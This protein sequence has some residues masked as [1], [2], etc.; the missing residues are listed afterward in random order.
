M[1]YKVTWHHCSKKFQNSKFKV[2]ESNFI[3]S[4]S[5]FPLIAVLSL[6]PFKP[7]FPKH[8]PLAAIHRR[9]PPNLRLRKWSERLRLK[10]KSPHLRMRLFPFLSPHFPKLKPNPSQSTKFQQPFNT[11]SGSYSSLHRLEANFINIWKYWLG[12]FTSHLN[13]S[14]SAYSVSLMKL[15]TLKIL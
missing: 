12:Q 6:S 11:S 4:L 15:L 10:V 14:V 8:Y 9:L 13:S 7:N 2:V 5:Q 1:V 3:I